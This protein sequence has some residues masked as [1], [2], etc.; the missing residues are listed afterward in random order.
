MDRL[1]YN[2]VKS[3][4]GSEQGQRREA[5]GIMAPNMI[6]VILGYVCVVCW[7]GYKLY[8]RIS[9]KP[10]RRH[11]V[12]L[13]VLG[14]VGRSPRMMYHAQS[15]AQHEWEAVIVGYR[16]T[17]PIPSLLG[18]PHVHF[19]HITNPPTPLLLLPWVLRAPIRVLW[20]VYSV[21]RICLLDVP[22]YTE[23]MIVQNP[24]SIPTLLLAQIICAIGG[25]KLVVDWHN[26]GYSI[27]A[28]RTGEKSP[29]VKVAKW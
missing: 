12:T 16:D 6:K 29:L 10:F 9:T 8:H 25:T 14:D 17:L 27:L 13:L 3:P 23:Y 15:I 2:T 22:V 19:R 18:L 21:L 1:V 7:I 28:M 5:T 11:A 20:Q 4:T 26:T 24:P